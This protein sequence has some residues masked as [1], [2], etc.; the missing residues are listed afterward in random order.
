MKITFTDRAQFEKAVGIVL[1][2]NTRLNSGGKLD[3]GYADM[4]F[5]FF[6]SY[7]GQRAVER[8]KAKEI[9]CFTVDESDTIDA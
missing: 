6:D 9:A 5:S 3:I 7:H 4:I 2:P 1:S 8:L